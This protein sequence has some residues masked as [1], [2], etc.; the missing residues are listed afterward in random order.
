M[1]DPSALMFDPDALDPEAAVP[2]II[3]ALRR[4]GSTEVRREAARV[5]A[6]WERVP[7]VEAL[8]GALLD[9]DKE[10]AAAA[11][12]SLSEL[13]DAASGHVLLHWV[14]SPV[15]FVQVAVLRAL[16]ELR[17]T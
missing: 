9:A 12:Q 5:L 3:D 6:A 13:K 10:V 11:A 15:P 1:T 7:V 2:P 8:C 17:L 16:R 4:D 14:G